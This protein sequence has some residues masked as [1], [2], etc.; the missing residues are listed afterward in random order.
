MDRIKNMME[1]NELSII[2]YMM[3]DNKWRSALSSFYMNAVEN[4]NGKAYML[5]VQGEIVAYAILWP[6]G[7][8]SVIKYI[9]TDPDKRRNGYAS[10]LIK[11]LAKT[12]K[13][14]LRI[15]ILH[16]LPSYEALS[17]CVRKAGF[18]LNDTSCVYS[19]EVTD[20]FW[21]RMDD[22][23]FVRM[24]EFV[25]RDGSE[26]ISFCEMD[27]GIAKQLRESVGSAF[28][29]TLNPVQFMDREEGK[30]DKELSY[31]L[32]KAGELQSYTLITRP[33]NSLACFEQIA[34]AKEHL[35]SGMI[36]GPLCSTL[37]NIRY[38]HP[39]ITR[40]NM[41]VSDS[42]DKSNGLI[43]GIFEGMDIQEVRNDSYV[44]I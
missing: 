11:E 1:L 8:G 29:N 3:L 30:L 16:T 38:N 18:R 17:G 10:K 31:V 28:Q 2:A 26:C 20:A 42:N 40:I 37:E 6:E 22:L 5:S 4:G 34:E 19:V 41:T 21:K 27:D 43:L 33:Q 25:L 13:A 7:K 36:L 24:K 39:E 32:I 9:F 15:H 14:Y 35:V 23:K 44:L 12:Q